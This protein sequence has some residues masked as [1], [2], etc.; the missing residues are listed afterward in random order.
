[1]IIEHSTRF[2]GLEEHRLIKITVILSLFLWVSFYYMWR[3][4]A[5]FAFYVSMLGA[6]ISD[7]TAF[8]FFYFMI[9]VSGATVWIVTFNWENTLNS[10]LVSDD[11]YNTIFTQYSDHAEVDSFISV[12]NLALGDFKLE[13]YANKTTIMPFLA[14]LLIS[15]IT[16]IVFLNMMIAVMSDTFNKMTEKRERNGLRERTMLYADFMQLLRIDSYLDKNRFLYI[17]TPKN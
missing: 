14:F 1:V 7:L 5:D 17:V 9:I 12:W 6:T 15:L 11:Q 3:L 16:N 8:L 2:I 13:N 4:E 10:E